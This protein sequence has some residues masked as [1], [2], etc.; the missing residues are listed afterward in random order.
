MIPGVNAHILA[1]LH[2]P[3][4]FVENAPGDSSPFSVVQ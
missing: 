2:A 3:L 4:H 1:R